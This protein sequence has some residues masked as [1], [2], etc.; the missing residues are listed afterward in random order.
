ML[1]VAGY[2]GKELVVSIGAHTGEGR[3]CGTVAELC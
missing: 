1:P 2:F 3:R